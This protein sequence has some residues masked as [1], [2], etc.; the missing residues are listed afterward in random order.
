MIKK[1]WSKFFVETRDASDVTLQTSVDAV[2]SV[3][4]GSM[5]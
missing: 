1:Y 4:T 3:E 5:T 2:V